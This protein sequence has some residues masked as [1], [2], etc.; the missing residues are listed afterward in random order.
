MGTQKI[1]QLSIKFI[2]SNER[3]DPLIALVIHILD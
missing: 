1:D 2:L 3:L